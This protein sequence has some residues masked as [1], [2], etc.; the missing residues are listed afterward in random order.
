MKRV[1]KLGG[2]ALCLAVLAG[3]TAVALTTRTTLDFFFPGVDIDGNLDDGLGADGI[4]KVTFNDRNGRLRLTGRA[5]VE[6]DSRR[7]QVYSDIGVLDGIDGDVVRDRYRVTARGRATYTGLVRNSSG[8][9]V[10]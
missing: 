7:T 5:V 8:I 6:N 2:I 3:S 4:V 1:S 10:L 9:E